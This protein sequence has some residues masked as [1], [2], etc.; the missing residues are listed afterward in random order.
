MRLAEIVARNNSII[1][2]LNKFV[3]MQYSE[4][5][6]L[7][8]I[9]HINFELSKSVDSSLNDFIKYDIVESFG[10]YA[11]NPHNLFTALI[12]NGLYYPQSINYNDKFEVEWGTFSLYN[13]VVYF[14]ERPLQEVRESR[15]DKIL[16]S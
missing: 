9:Q 12:F 1:S 14:E 2:G 13:G 6:K 11:I 10:K 15:L 8:I 7:L 5:T 3:G 4:K 16:N